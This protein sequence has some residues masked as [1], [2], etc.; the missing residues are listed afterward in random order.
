MDFSRELSAAEAE[1]DACAKL[2]DGLPASRGRARARRGEEQALSRLR[3]ADARLG[4]LTL[5]GGDA[6]RHGAAL[7]RAVSLASRLGELDLVRANAERIM[8]LPPAGRNTLRKLEAGTTLMCDCAMCCDYPSALATLMDLRKYATGKAGVG[9][10]LAAAAKLAGALADCG[11][12]EE[13]LD[14]YSDMRPF[15]RWEASRQARAE[16]ASKIVAGL[17]LAGDL[18][19][20]FAVFREMASYSTDAEAFLLYMRAGLSLLL[21]LSRS[22]EQGRYAFLARALSDPSESPEA[23]RV[24]GE[25]ALAYV[26]E[27]AQAGVMDEARA[28]LDAFCEF[29]GA[30]LVAVHRAR[31]AAAVACAYMEDSR[32]DEARLLLESLTFAPAKAPSADDRLVAAG[33]KAGSPAVQAGSPAVQADSTIG[34]AGSPACHTDAATDQADLAS[35]CY[36]ALF[37]ATMRLTGEYVDC[38]MISDARTFCRLMADAAPDERDALA[39]AE[40]ALASVEDCCRKGFVLEALSLYR[41]FLPHRGPEPVM[42]LACRMGSAAIRALCGMAFTDEAVEALSTLPGARRPGDR[43][44]YERLQAE[45]DTFNALLS[46]G[47]YGKAGRLYRRRADYRGPEKAALKWLKAAERLVESYAEEGALAKARSVFEHA[48]RE[49]P[50]GGKFALRFFAMAQE[51]ISGYCENGDLKNARG[52]FD[53]LPG[54]G[55]STRLEEEKSEISFFLTTYYCRKGEL[56]DALAFFRSLPEESATGRLPFLKARAAAWLIADLSGRGLVEEAASVYESL[57]G[58]GPAD[59]LELVRAKSAIRLVSAFTQSENTDRALELLKTIPGF[60]DPKRVGRQLSGAVMALSLSLAKKNEVDK[61]ND[62]R[63]FTTNFL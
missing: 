8:A 58:M 15:Q 54:T 48:R 25:A 21:P 43:I 63:S 56:Q 39:F 13:A 20:A 6:D 36:R 61:A 31:A 12:S 52:L 16:A 11:R 18:E 47:L 34:K 9:R 41:A 28:V 10:W 7:A 53:G 46:S 19:K 55:N 51:L 5:S 38:M 33:G 44:Y 24:R 14:I 32:L 2:L 60:C 62:L 22:P 45:T 1:L 59:G 3:A 49:A 35:S 17:K 27:L 4:A 57:V 50:K 23:S 40:A 26:E 30:Q 42:Y 29:S 37:D